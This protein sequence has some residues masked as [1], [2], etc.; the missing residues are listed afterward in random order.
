MML[1]SGMAAA[2]RNANVDDATRQDQS[3][4]LK[5]RQRRT[6]AKDDWIASCPAVP[7]SASH[8]P[9]EPHAGFAA[10]VSIIQSLAP[11][12]GYVNLASTAA[13][14]SASYVVF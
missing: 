11:Y 9:P 10:P 6:H 8:A 14:S 13:L 4:S 12:D 2:F 3:R 5:H 7:G 1:L